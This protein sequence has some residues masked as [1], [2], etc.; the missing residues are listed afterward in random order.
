MSNCG[1]HYCCDRIF[2][3]CDCVVTCDCLEIPTVKKDEDGNPLVE[4]LV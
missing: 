1:W 4:G 2:D 3:K